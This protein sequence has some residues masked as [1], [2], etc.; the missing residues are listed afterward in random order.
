MVYWELGKTL[1]YLIKSW[2]LSDIQAVGI[3]KST[4][5]LTTWSVNQQ[6][7]TNGVREV[8]NTTSYLRM[9]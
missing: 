1:S 4:L 2:S 6:E 3:C 7:R 5:G 8:A 9:Q